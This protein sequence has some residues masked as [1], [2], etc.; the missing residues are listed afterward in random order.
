MNRDSLLK[1]LAIR[2]EAARSR[3][4]HRG[5]EIHS[6]AWHRIHCESESDMAVSG[7]RRRMGRDSA[8]AVAGLPL[9]A[10]IIG[11]KVIPITRAVGSPPG[12]RRP[13]EFGDSR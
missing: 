13:R 8:A 3:G 10:R 1:E 2:I 9:D 11:A 12:H 5:V 7:L 4:D 6:A